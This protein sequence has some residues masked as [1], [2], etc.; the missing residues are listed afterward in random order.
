MDFFFDSSCL[1]VFSPRSKVFIFLGYFV[2]GLFTPRSK[3]W[4]SSLVLRV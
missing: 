1:I 4:I 3:E 2:F